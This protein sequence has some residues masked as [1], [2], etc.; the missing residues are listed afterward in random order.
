MTNRPYLVKAKCSTPYCKS[1]PRKGKKI[2]STCDKRNWRQK[3]PMKACFQTLRQNCT[4]RGK[5]FAITFEYFKL[6]CYKTKYMAGK[7]RSKTSYSID[8]IEPY[9]GYVEG[10]IRKV[11]V[12]ENSSKG[13]KI[14]IYDYRD[15]EF[16]TV[17]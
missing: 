3:F 17:V 9:L 1:K 11:T 2:C 4:R 14:L 13:T 8:C 6:F 16:T 15:P 12:P 10:N 7:G 5:I